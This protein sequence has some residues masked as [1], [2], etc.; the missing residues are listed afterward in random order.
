MIVVVLALGCYS[1]L[2][3]VAEDAA[4]LGA[5]QSLTWQACLL[6]ASLSL[7]NYALR[8]VRWHLYLRELG[9]RLSWHV[10]ALA[11]FSGFALT[12][13]PAKVG[14]AFRCVM[15]ANHQVPYSRS[16]ATSLVERMLDLGV[17]VLLATPLLIVDSDYA[18]F[19]AVGFLIVAVI[20]IAIVKTNA[21]TLLGLLPRSWSDKLSSSIDA[22]DNLLAQAR[23]LLNARV[24]FYGSVLGGVAWAAEGVGLYLILSYLGEPQPLLWT[25]AIYAVATLVGALTFMPGG[26]GT[27]EAALIVL[28]TASGMDFSIATAATLICRVF[29]L[30]FAILLGIVCLLTYEL[31]GFSPSNVKL[32]SQ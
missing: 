1:V 12:A 19:L 10:D 11:Y 16:M 3:L 8:M 24:L 29:T 23:G 2:V 14:E 13:T 7:V 30:W 17:I 4:V 27:T 18:W 22:F 21:S 26:L 9:T 5:I 25:V 28:L 15:L 6:I 31:F 32:E 20:T